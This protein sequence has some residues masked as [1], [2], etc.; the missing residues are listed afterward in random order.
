MGPGNNRVADWIAFCA[1]KLRSVYSPEEATTISKILVFHHSGVNDIE[2]L[3]NPSVGFTESEILKVHFDM[4]RLMKHEPIQYVL[5][6]L[7]FCGLT[8]KVDTRALIPR[9]ETEEMVSKIINDTRNPKRILDVGT[10]T[11]CIALTLK[12]AFGDADVTAIEPNAEAISLARENAARQHLDV[13]FVQIEIENYRSA[14]PYDLI[15]S[16]PPYV[17]ERERSSMSKNVLDHEPWQALFVPDDD[18]LKY[19]KLIFEAKALATGGR[20]WFEVNARHGDDLVEYCRSAGLTVELINDFSGRVR[21][22][23]GQA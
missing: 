10:G 16:N 20:F 8:L 2:L 6:E 21:F 7:E 4:K 11:G 17:L 9:P 23:K 13:K 1:Q 18:P 22:V 5:G 19:Y 14:E 12:A 3:K 15:V